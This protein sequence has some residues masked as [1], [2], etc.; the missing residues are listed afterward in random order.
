MKKYEKRC[1]Y[2][3]T[4]FET[5]KY[6]TNYC[7]AKCRAAERNELRHRVANKDILSAVSE[8]EEYNRTHGT[9]LSYGQYINMKEGGK[10]NGKIH[11]NISHGER[12]KRT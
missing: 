5:T 2:C 12:G 11:R 4:I 1:F 3:G 9:C 8:C 6:D 7:S 10:T